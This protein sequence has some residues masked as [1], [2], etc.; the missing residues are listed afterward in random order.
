MK[1]SRYILRT[2][3]L[4]SVLMVVL[5]AVTVNGQ[6]TDPVA[7]SAPVSAAINAGQQYFYTCTGCHGIPDY[8]NVYPTYKVPMVGGQNQQY[9]IN[10]LHAYKN[11]TRQHSTMEI[12]A[13]SMTEQ[14]II[15][16]AAYLSSLT[17]KEPS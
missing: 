6:N 3:W 10:A 12:Q 2:G 11:G 17:I 15:N 8:N 7:T 14:D 16:V 1:L 13:Q 4:V 5:L 9:I